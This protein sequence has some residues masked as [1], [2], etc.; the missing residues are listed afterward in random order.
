MDNDNVDLKVTVMQ[1]INAMLSGG[2][3][4]TQE[5]VKK[6]FDIAN[7]VDKLRKGQMKAA[8]EVQLD[9]YDQMAVEHLSTDTPDPAEA[10]RDT[11]A[12][13][14]A[15]AAQ[16]RSTPVNDVLASLL[17]HL[18]LVRGEG[19][20]G[21][22]AWQTID[23]FVQM[24]AA[25]PQ[26]KD[27]VDF[28]KLVCKDLLSLLD[29]SL[30]ITEAAA[31][32]G[33]AADSIKEI[34]DSKTSSPEEKLDKIS[35]IFTSLTEQLDDVKAKLAKAQENALLGG[36]AGSDGGA[37][38]PPP[39]PGPDGGFVVPPP[40]PGPGGEGGIPPAPDGPGVIPPPPP[41]P[42]GIPP[43]PPGPGGRA[44][45]DGM[46][47]PPPPGPAAPSRPKKASPK[48]SVP[49][50][51]FNWA[52]ISDAKTLDTIWEKIS[53]D[54]VKVNQKEL[55]QFFA[56]AQKKEAA[57][58]EG[59]EAAPA[60]TA[61]GEKG[62]AKAA[63]KKNISM[64]DPRRG[65]NVSIMLAR[66]KMPSA[67][68]RKA[69]ETLDEAVLSADNLAALKQYIPTDEEIAA[70]MEVDDKESLNIADK[71]FLE[72]AKIPNLAPRLECLHARATFAGKAGTVAASVDVLTKG[73]L[74][75][76]N[77]KTFTKYLE[78]VLKIGNILNGGS[79]RGGAYGFKLDSLV[80]IV[81]VR[82]A[83]KE[84]PTLLHYIAAKA[85]TDYKELLKMHTEFVELNNAAKE[86]FSQLSSDLAALE[87]A[88]RLVEAQIKK[89]EGGT[90]PKPEGE[91]GEKEKAPSPRATP[92]RSLSPN[93]PF[94]VAMKQFHERASKGYTN[95]ANKLK[96]LEAM[97]KE[98]LTFYG[99][100]P[101][102]PAEAFLGT[103]A[104]GIS[105]FDKA[106]DDNQKRRAAA[107]KAVEAE[108][109]REALKKK[110]AASKPSP[111]TPAGGPN[112]RNVMDNLIGQ[113]H[114]GDAFVGRAALRSAQ[115]RAPTKESGE[116]GQMANEALAIFAKMKGK[117]ETVNT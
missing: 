54:H 5:E 91:D 84:T 62:P 8:L 97:V 50:K 20:A 13:F 28:G 32:G 101:G 10:K 107:A 109:R 57:P 22:I 79:F 30:D 93:D 31:G 89:A 115:S 111:D 47:V 81:D 80:K 65:Q 34:M 86:S 18:M 110:T 14:N 67:D 38:V 7:V 52:K 17:Q 96:A 37:V 77:S 24:A 103:V 72:L 45:G 33:K 83:N 59:G 26:A 117:R 3:E 15:L 106:V 116:K 95:I 12:L 71:Y 87:K 112:D 16:V 25:A 104:R 44:R 100:E 90:A 66:F 61:G 40:P 73:C 69:I 29:G 63:A 55:E 56:S 9:V 46:L 102:T 76:K 70:I 51:Q 41:G 64:L 4:A 74:E 35:R 92:Q 43:P 11:V 114:T 58:S 108:A 88:L 1:L 68:I 2:D 94:I 78:V 53:D 99:E 82:P 39:P 19:K 21:K 75:V 42:G 27:D 49:L 113:L 98:L 85:E 48:P 23:K 6:L 60:P 36:T 105:L